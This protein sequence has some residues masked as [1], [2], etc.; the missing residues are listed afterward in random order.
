MSTLILSNVFFFLIIHFLFKII[1]KNQLKSIA[2][3]TNVLVLN[4][5]NIN[6]SFYY[7]I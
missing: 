6:F 2:Q 3:K 1:I 4:V 7:Y 5:E